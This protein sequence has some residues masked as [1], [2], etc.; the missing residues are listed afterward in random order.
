MSTSMKNISQ[1]RCE[2]IESN[3]DVT[4]GS[5]NKPNKK[6]ELAFAFFVVWRSGRDSN[7]RPPA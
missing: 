2:R 4:L 3:M 6:G 1:R 5:A 7:P